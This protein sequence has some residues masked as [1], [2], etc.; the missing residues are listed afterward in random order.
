MIDQQ[1]HLG[2]AVVSCPGHDVPILPTSGVMAE[3]VLWSVVSDI[4]AGPMPA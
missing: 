1:W 2:D 3:A 4:L